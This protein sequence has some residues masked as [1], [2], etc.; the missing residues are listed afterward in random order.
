MTET[1][2]FTET[3]KD[4][5]A[6]VFSQQ[7]SSA[8]QEVALG[9]VEND[10]KGKLTLTFDVKRIGESHQVQ[11]SHSLQFIRPTKRGD[12]RETVKTSTPMH[13]GRG[14]RLSFTPASQTDMFK[15]PEKG[16]V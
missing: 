1:Y 11:I 16:A 2:D 15:S 8:M 9:V 4:L 7:V 13:V 3:L 6:G 14:G 12:K 5:D 10:K